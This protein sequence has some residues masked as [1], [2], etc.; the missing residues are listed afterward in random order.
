MDT[1][2]DS[3]DTSDSRDDLFD[4]VDRACAFDNVYD[5]DMHEPGD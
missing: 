4:C 5:L 3:D 1:D 2:T